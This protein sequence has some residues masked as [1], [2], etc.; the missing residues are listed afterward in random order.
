MVEE[1]DNRNLYLAVSSPNLN[2][3]I[4]TLPDIGSQV[5]GQER[6]YSF[7]QEVEV[8]VTY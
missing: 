7:S 6:F 5:D 2:F 1:V 4:S 8:Q 3:N